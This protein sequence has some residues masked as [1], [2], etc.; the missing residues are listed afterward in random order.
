[1]I[2]GEVTPDKEALVRLMVRGP[3]G[4]EREVCAVLDTGY[5]EYLTLLPTLITALG[6]PYQY[7]L[8]M[9][10]ADGSTV[11]MRVFDAAVVW[12]NRERSIPVQETDGDVL[13]GM[14]LLYGPRLLLDAVD[15][16]HVAISDIP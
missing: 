11:Q 13:L 2:I 14:S 4:Q 8:P 10:L 15:G 6:L 7:S 3:G 16:G 5:T 9:S 12:N 1:M